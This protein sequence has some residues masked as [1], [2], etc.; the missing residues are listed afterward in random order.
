MTQARQ[1]MC[2]N[3]NRLAEFHLCLEV[4]KLAQNIL[5]VVL[6]RS[7]RYFFGV[8]VQT[9]KL[10]GGRRLSTQSCFCSSISDRRYLM[11]WMTLRL[12]CMPAQIIQTMAFTQN[13]DIRRPWRSLEE[14][15][16]N[17]SRSQI[18]QRI[19]GSYLYSSEGQKSIS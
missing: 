17:A 9:I 18:D 5:K 4:Q 8:K 6:H 3:S 10:I 19:A 1:N 7:H 13:M 16:Q 14:H 11:V 12:V 15:L 2:P